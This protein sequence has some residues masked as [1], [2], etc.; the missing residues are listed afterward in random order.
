MATQAQISAKTTDALV[1]AEIDRVREILDFDGTADLPGD[2][3][4]LSRIAAL[5]GEQNQRLKAYVDDWDAIPALPV[6]R[7]GGPKG[8][9]YSTVDHQRQV[10][11]RTRALLGYPLIGVSSGLR[12]IGVGYDY[13]GC[14]VERDLYD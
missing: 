13:A 7:K 6:A 12:R 2:D 10:R 11:N 3:E 5:A 8:T 9:F 1:A 14:P 4:L